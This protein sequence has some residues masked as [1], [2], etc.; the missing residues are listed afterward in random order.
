VKRG[1][2]LNLHAELERGTSA[3]PLRAARERPDVVARVLGLV[4]P[5]DVVI[6]KEEDLSRVD[7]VH[8][9]CPTASVRALWARAKGTPDGRRWPPLA[10]IERVLSRRW[11]AERLGLSLP[12]A[13]L[14]SERADLEAALSIDSP[15]GSL[16]LRTMRGFAGKGRRVCRIGA[17]EEADRSFAEKAIREGGLLVEPLVATTQDLSLHGFVLPPGDG[18]RPILGHVVSSV[19]G[20]GG[21]WLDA[22]RADLEEGAELLEPLRGEAT[23]AGMALAEDGYWGPFGV[24]VIRF[25]PWEG[26][27]WARCEVNARYSMAWGVGMGTTRPDLLPDP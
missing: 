12:G 14:V 4:P 6:T 23:R 21:V 1:W 27:T 17:P 9:W 24:D 16:L 7:A 15:T 19:V 10:V 25:R 8:A 26:R 11:N 3:D 13:R 2:I 18:G 5:G 20:P 22:R